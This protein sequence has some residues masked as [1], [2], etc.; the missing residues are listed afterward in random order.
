M[1]KKI[2]LSANALTVLE[3]RYLKKDK[4]KVTEKPED[5][6]KRVAQN[7]S[8][9]EL[10]YGKE[11]SE[12]EKI[13]NDF[14][15]L[16][17][18]LDFLPN[19]PTLMNAGNELQQLAACFV[20]PVEDSMESIF[21]T[22]KHAA[23]IHK[24]GGGTGFS[25]SRLRPQRDRVLT[26]GGVASGPISFMKV[27]NAAT[28]AVKQGGT[29]RGANMGILRV[30]HPDILEFIKI[31]EDNKEL[32]NFNLS[33]G[34]TE[35]FMEAVEKGETYELI[36]PRNGEV[37]KQLMAKEV[38]DLLIDSSWK[39]GEPGIIFLDRMNETNPTPKI[40]EIESTN[41][42]GEQPLL[43]YEACNLGSINLA[44]FVN[45]GKLDYKHLRTAIKLSVR[46]LDNV[47]DMGQYPLQQITDIVQANRKIGLGV[48]GFADSL[49]K[50]GIPY[51][52]EGAVTFA[53]EIMGFIQQE[54]KVASEELAQERGSF[55]NFEMSVYPGKGMKGLRN[56]TTTTIAPTGTISII[57]GVSSGIEPLFAVCYKRNILDNDE[58]LEVHPLFEELAKNR[59]FY[60]EGL[61]EEIAEKGTVR[62]IKGIPIDIQQLFVTAHD[63]SPQWH[64][65]IQAAFQKYTDNAVSKT[66]NF[67]NEAT[68]ED[69]KEVFMLSYKLKCKGVTVYRDGSRDNQVLTKGDV[70]KQ[71]T[72]K[73]EAFPQALAEKIIPRPRPDV[74]MGV[75]EKAKIGCGN[76]YISVN[77]DEYGICEVFTNTGRE[78]GCS[79]QSEATSRLISVALRSGISEQTIMEQLKG[80]RCP[81]CIRRPGINVTSCPDAIAKAIKKVGNFTLQNKKATE[82]T[83][84][85]KDKGEETDKPGIGCPECGKTIRF[86]SGC[87]I[88]TH[89]GYSKCG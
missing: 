23:L 85:A 39:S 76:L 61:M 34:I 70:K 53:E 8:E 52:S 9:A 5:M 69:I 65:Q 75:T 71:S 33:V 41:P 3:R 22:I 27:F 56:A 19:S 43:P 30:D 73:M 72:A 77:S 16:M 42:C 15:E 57:A 28:E 81:A 21:E 18:K 20:L 50:L 49:I 89:C 14:Y 44:N 60:S 51:N 63:I 54:T 13:A 29:R 11:D 38:F 66:V 24:S 31:K 78:G 26:T 46:F 86:E 55:P 67:H 48:M 35:A 68:R 10:R 83:S 32:T 25:F 87:V 80:I 40:G 12:V 84:V 47:I 79:S 2:E 7:I 88:C 64:V 58:L 37:V 17:T 59:G 36:N 74:T 82:E 6:F 62:G 4:G 1:N 45:K